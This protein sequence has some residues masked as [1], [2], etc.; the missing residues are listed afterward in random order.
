[1]QV[2]LK[3][4]VDGNAGEQRPEHLQTGLEQEEYQRETDQ[5]PV[6]AHV[7]Q[8]PAHQPGVV[9]FSEDL[10]FHSLQ[11]SVTLMARPSAS[12][13]APAGIINYIACYDF[14]RRK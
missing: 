13:A 7:A 12:P 5:Q 2:G 14:G 4:P 3:I 6:G 10:F 11:S 8:Q 9:R 1:M